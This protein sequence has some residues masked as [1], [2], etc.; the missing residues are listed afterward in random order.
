MADFSEKE[1]LESVSDSS[2]SNPKCQHSGD[3]PL[4]SHQKHFFRCAAM[5]IGTVKMHQL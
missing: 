3:E 5:G 4:C 1:N 2:S